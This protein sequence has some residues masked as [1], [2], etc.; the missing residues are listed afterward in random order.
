MHRDSIA[1]RRLAG[2]SRGLDSKQFVTDLRDGGFT[3]DQAIEALRQ[4]FG[5]PHGAAR[6]FVV[7][8]PAW[9]AEAPAREP[10]GPASFTR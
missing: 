10:D 3:R 9:A 2:L 4:V 6:L 7:S 5:V 8:H 1:L